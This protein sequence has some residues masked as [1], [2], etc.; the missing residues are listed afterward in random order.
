M[1]T[2]LYFGILYCA[3]ISAMALYH[4]SLSV[5]FSVV[6]L[7]P[8]SAVQLHLLLYSLSQRSGGI[9]VEGEED[10]VVLIHWT[11]F[12]PAPLLHGSRAHLVVQ[13]NY[14]EVF[15]YLFV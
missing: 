11:I 4:R 14:F 9:G 2:V 12:H 15:V 6:F 8:C 7:T 10:I 13:L 1:H 3:V 5:L